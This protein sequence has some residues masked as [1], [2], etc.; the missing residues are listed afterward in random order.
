LKV[1]I[2]V[3]MVEKEETNVKTVTYIFS[4][5]C[6]DCKSASSGKMPQRILSSLQDLPVFLCFPFLQDGDLLF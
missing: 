1:K 2:K 5:F 3:E 4:N 6:S